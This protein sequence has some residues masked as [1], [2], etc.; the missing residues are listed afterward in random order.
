MDALLCLPMLLYFLAQRNLINTQVQEN[1]AS[2]GTPTYLPTSLGC[3]SLQDLGRN[4]F[5]VTTPFMNP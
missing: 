4:Q 3:Y 5:Y 1:L 2:L